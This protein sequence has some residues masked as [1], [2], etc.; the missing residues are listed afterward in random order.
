MLYN[1]VP[2]PGLPIDNLTL[3]KCRA[4]NT[5]YEV[6]TTGDFIGGCHND[7]FAN[8]KITQHTADCD[9]GAPLVG[10]FRQDHKQIHI[11]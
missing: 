3:E 6:S 9:S 11:A 4:K 2:P 7:I 5:S 8:R 1:D 10:H